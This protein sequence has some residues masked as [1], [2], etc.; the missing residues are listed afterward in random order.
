LW[1][2]DDYGGAVDY[3]DVCHQFD[4]GIN[5]LGTALVNRVF[6]N[7]TMNVNGRMKACV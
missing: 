7:A 1:W 5:S 2:D 4:S 6:L 3:I